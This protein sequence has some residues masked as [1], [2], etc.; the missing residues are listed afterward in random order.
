MER[1]CTIEIP[2]DEL[3]NNNGMKDLAALFG[4]GNTVTITFNI[5]NWER[6]PAEPAVGF[7]NDFYYATDVE[8]T[9]I[10]VSDEDGHLDN[11][12][13]DMVEKG[14]IDILKECCIE[15]CN[16]NPEW[17]EKEVDAET[18]RR[19]DSMMEDRWERDHGGDY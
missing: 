15:E 5:T 7:F 18:D 14:I 3:A 16:N 13:V 12:I 10:E 17:V 8:I 9:D 19:Y 2:S 6:E 4:K 11:Y 1:T